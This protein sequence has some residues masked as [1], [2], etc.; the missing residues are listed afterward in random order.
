MFKLFIH[1]PVL[2]IKTGQGEEY[3][4]KGK[5]LTPAIRLKIIPFIIA[6]G[7]LPGVLFCIEVSEKQFRN[8]VI[9]EERT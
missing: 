2:N 3:P 9:R 1:V 4:S 7:Q 5:E 6:I 8:K